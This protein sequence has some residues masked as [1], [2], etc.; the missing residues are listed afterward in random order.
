MELLRRTML[1]TAKSSV[2]Q[3]L[4][5]PCFKT[6]VRLPCDP[7]HEACYNALVDVRCSPLCAMPQPITGCFWS[8]AASTAVLL[9]PPL[10]CRA[11]K[12][13]CGSPAVMKDVSSRMLHVNQQ[14]S[15]V[16]MNFRTDVAAL[17]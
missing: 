15:L 12:P 1:R 13:S 14:V 5:P 10:A 8:L 3:T 2:Q 6:T 11:T 17:R 7:A 16:L 9:C 4:L